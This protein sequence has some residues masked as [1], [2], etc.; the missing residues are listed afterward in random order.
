MGDTAILFLNWTLLIV[1]GLNSA[2]ETILK[3]KNISSSVKMKKQRNTET[4][5]VTLQY[6]NQHDRAFN[7]PAAE[8]LLPALNW[9]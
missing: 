1:N 2:C 3:L 5:P 6:K 8:M 9:Q 4:L 7:A